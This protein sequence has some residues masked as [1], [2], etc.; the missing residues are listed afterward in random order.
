MPSPETLA[1]DQITAF[2]HGYARAVEAGDIVAVAA[3]YSRD[4]HRG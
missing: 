1:R 3:G 4:V 2:P